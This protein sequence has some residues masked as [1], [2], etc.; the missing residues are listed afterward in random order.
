MQK[1]KPLLELGKMRMQN[2]NVG[3]FSNMMDYV[4]AHQEYGASVAAVYFTPFPL[5]FRRN[6]AVAVHN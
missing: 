3:F 4:L 2:C 5:M 6:K 1:K